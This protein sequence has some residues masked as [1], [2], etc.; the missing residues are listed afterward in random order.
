MLIQVFPNHTSFT[1]EGEVLPPARPRLVMYYPIEATIEANPL[2]QLLLLA[3]PHFLQYRPS[4]LAATLLYMGHSRIVSPNGDWSSALVALTGYTEQ[5]LAVCFSSLQRCASS[6]CRG[7]CLGLPPA[8]RSTASCSGS[9]L[10]LKAGKV[11]S[12]AL[13]VHVGHERNT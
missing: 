4:L 2:I 11:D 7:T 3:E 8:A 10:A 13:A 5:D 1:T 12:A 6:A 9:F